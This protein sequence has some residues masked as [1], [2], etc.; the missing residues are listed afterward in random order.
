M[1]DDAATRA[2]FEAL[3]PRCLAVMGILQ[4]GAVPPSPA[5]GRA[6]LEALIELLPTLPPAGLPRCID[7]VLIP[8]SMLSS[9]CLPQ[10]NP[11][12]PGSDRLLE[13]SLRGI[14]ALADAAGPAAF[15]A[16]PVRFADVAQLALGVVTDVAAQTG[17]PGSTGKSQSAV[18]S[19]EALGA[20]LGALSCVCEQA[21]GVR[22]LSPRD[23]APAPLARCD[24]G[25]GNLQVLS[26]VA[27]ADSRG[28]PAV[29]PP[30]SSP[31][32]AALAIASLLHIAT[33]DSELPGIGDRDPAAAE[34]SGFD[35]PDGG[36]AHRRQRFAAE[37]RFAALRAFVAVAAALSRPAAPDF[38]PEDAAAL[39]RHFR[40]DGSVAE[41]QGASDAPSTVSPQGT[42]LA[43]F[44]PGC[45]AALARVMLFRPASQPELRGARGH[46]VAS[47]I[48]ALAVLLR[49]VFGTRLQPQTGNDGPSDSWW[50]EA[51]NRMASLV[52]QVFAA[53]TLPLVS[54]KASGP[55]VPALRAAVLSLAHSVIDL[56][57]ASLEAAPHAQLGGE[58]LVAAWDAIF[59]LESRVTD[60]V[61]GERWA[62]P[63][64]LP[65]LAF[66]AARAA[67]LLLRL[68]EV[69]RPRDA[70]SASLAVHADT[71]TAAV[72]SIAAGIPSPESA[73]DAVYS[74]LV[75]F[76]AA[77]SLPAL[78]L[79]AGISL[80]LV[81]QWMRGLSHRSLLLVLRVT[82]ETWCHC[83]ASFETGVAQP[84]LV[85]AAL[86]D[87]STWNVWVPKLGRF[88]FAI[89]AFPVQP[90]PSQIP[91]ESD[92]AE[93]HFWSDA[94]WSRDAVQVDLCAELVVFIDRICDTLGDKSAYMALELLHATLGRSA[95]RLGRERVPA[96]DASLRSVIQAAGLPSRGLAV[97]NKSDVRN[98]RVEDDVM[99]CADVSNATLDGP[100][101]RASSQAPPGEGLENALAPAYSSMLLLSSDSLPFEARGLRRTS[102]GASVLR[103]SASDF[104]SS[105]AAA[106]EVLTLGVQIDASRLV[107]GAPV[108]LD[109][110]VAVAAAVV[111]QNPPPC[112]PVALWL[113]ARVV[114]TLG[115]LLREAGVSGG[116]TQDLGACLARIVGLAV[117]LLTRL[118]ADAEREGVADADAQLARLRRKLRRASPRPSADVVRSSPAVVS[119]WTAASACARLRSPCFLALSVSPAAACIELLDGGAAGLARAAI[120]LSAGIAVLE[121]ADGRVEDLPTS[122]AAEQSVPASLLDELTL[123]RVLPGLVA[124]R[125]HVVVQSCGLV[126]SLATA[127]GP[128][129]QGAVAALLPPLVALSSG[130]PT[131][132]S[133]SVD[134]QS[135]LSPT[136]VGAAAIRALAAT[137][138]GASESVRSAA[139]TA[140][141][142]LSRC[143]SGHYSDWSAAIPLP[144]PLR[145]AGDDE[146]R[147]VKSVALISAPAPG[148][149]AMTTA[150]LYGESSTLADGAMQ[151]L[152]DCSSNLASGTASALVNGAFRS[153]IDAA[154]LVTGVARSVG[155][156]AQERRTRVLVD[157][158]QDYAPTDLHAALVAPNVRVATRDLAA[159]QDLASGICDTLAAVARTSAQSAA[160]MQR[161]ELRLHEVGEVSIELVSSA[162]EVVL[163]IVSA[164]MPADRRWLALPVNRLKDRR[165]VASD[166]STWKPLI[167][168]E[169]VSKSEH[170]EP[171]PPRGLA[172]TAPRESP[173][174][175]LP[176]SPVL[177]RAAARS[178]DVAMMRHSQ[179]MGHQASVAVANIGGGASA[180][181]SSIRGLSHCFR[182]RAVPEAGPVA[183]G[184]ANPASIEAPDVIAVTISSALPVLLPAAQSLL[185]AL[186]NATCRPH[187]GS[188]A[189]LIRSAGGRS[190]H[191]V[192][193][194][195]EALQQ[196]RC[197]A[198]SL[199]LFATAAVGLAR[200]PAQLLPLLN[201][202]WPSLATLLPPANV[203]I[204]ADG[205][206]FCSGG[207]R[208]A[209]AVGAST[210]PAYLDGALCSVLWP[211]E[212]SAASSRT[213]SASCAAPQRSV[214]SNGLLEQMGG[215]GDLPLPAGVA[216][217]ARAGGS[218][219]VPGESSLRRTELMEETRAYMAERARALAGASPVEQSVPSPF[220]G[221]RISTSKP[222][223]A[224][225]SRDESALRHAAEGL[226]VASLRPVPPS[227]A[228]GLTWLPA[229]I[230]GSTGL[231]TI[232]PA[233]PGL[234]RWIPGSLPPHVLA[235]HL[236]ALQVKVWAHMRVPPKI[237]VRDVHEHSSSFLQVVTALASHPV[238]AAGSCAEATR[239]ISAAT[240]GDPASVFSN[241]GACAADFLASRFDSDVWPSLRSLLASV[242]LAVASLTQQTQR[243]SA[244]VL[245]RAMPAHELLVG[246]LRMVALLA[247]PAITIEREPDPEE[248]S[249]QANE[250]RDAAVG[251]EI[252]ERMP[253]AQA[254]DGSQ[255]GSLP[256]P[257][258]IPSFLPADSRARMASAAPVHPTVYSLGRSVLHRHVWECSCLLAATIV[259]GK[260]S[261][262]GPPSGSAAGIPV[263]PNEPG[264]ASILVALADA[265]LRALARYADSHV[266]N[267]ALSLYGVGSVGSVSGV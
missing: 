233:S 17:G 13:L 195:A 124:W 165:E 55:H 204:S 158:A 184:K 49:L 152:T 173:V 213:A 228:L 121:H 95:P 226:A 35:G 193:S 266:V 61:S 196:L 34:T 198:V 154:T 177:R 197:S 240:R 53:H 8:L 11:R 77:S 3:K 118:Q 140:L 223:A 232:V 170:T 1:G 186:V 50:V 212:S 12:P 129:L 242:A 58:A 81:H 24:V 43:P 76:S 86:G 182:G 46:V 6:S 265:A 181:V 260:A 243:G 22:L 67:A 209:S 90:V 185:V 202:L 169:L 27:V 190:I 79:S 9:A 100:P 66:C 257:P 120:A 33:V 21:S 199:R 157:S 203:S 217:S 142:A 94:L 146:S 131:A 139:L 110:D 261:A 162:A 241:V 28:L 119:L 156:A 149:I 251:D 114:A 52:T 99:L 141:M 101:T 104:A 125:A 168:G 180:V 143:R 23:P 71:L 188:A 97:V 5:I 96:A 62:V 38:S 63:P 262:R 106:S 10:A 80:R 224:L 30:L 249:S 59:L 244:R 150:L 47:S 253:V 115:R 111:L 164:G 122:S 210:T 176:M 108:A 135:N 219:D 14:S 192:F 4:G 189:A 39:E 234:S 263:T 208:S 218:G 109:G 74:E 238:L 126:E 57:D 194:S 179:L 127:C 69:L 7:Y 254:G 51:R 237:F 144:R 41:G 82:A 221:S 206:Y 68:P 26:G 187:I 159:L 123:M 246:A 88:L 18:V 60:A 19:E 166:P 48:V 259:A 103:R 56:C 32:T 205:A 44:L 267:Q 239:V 112:A 138:A 160:L 153:I 93:P 134:Y 258:T 137:S 247:R 178:A 250:A 207:E 167:P 148:V 84:P 85:F 231:S 215:W 40:G 42:L 45:A 83:R 36:R 174:R 155:A 227:S 102:D 98:S 136:L 15:L 225:Q 65:S 172:A 87:V 161:Q 132:P 235:V 31:L 128:A 163:A 255:A 70:S 236:A 113:T 20:A 229:T 91:P 252:A 175:T 256:T 248:A 105:F 222:A 147:P 92:T 133:P 116:A 72:A 37:T 230:A 117:P 220:V 54:T 183:C 29:L 78:S 264:P 89:A 16:D 145:V 64:R 216:S 25:T 214:Y 75:D 130:Q 200:H 245:L 191:D 211:P 73:D 107:R 2:A 201:D 171:G 151:R